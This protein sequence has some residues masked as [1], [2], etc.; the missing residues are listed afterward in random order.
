MMALDD[1]RPAAW[2]HMLAN[3]VAMLANPGSDGRRLIRNLIETS[4]PSARYLLWLAAQSMIA[5]KSEMTRRVGD[6]Y[7]LSRR[8][9]TW[10]RSTRR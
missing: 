9:L 1:A 6:V 2:K 7:A 4:A 10:R 5:S 8:P 3:N